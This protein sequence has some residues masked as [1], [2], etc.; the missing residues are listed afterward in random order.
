MGRL[1]VQ[2]SV[3]DFPDALEQ[4]ARRRPGGAVAILV[5]NAAMTRTHE[6]ARLGKPGDR[7]TQVSTVHGE[8]QELRLVVLPQVANI[9]AHVGRH[10]VPW[11]AQMVVKGFQS[12]LVYREFGNRS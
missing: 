11:R 10:A 1:D 7:A 9:D 3:A 8:N 5:I 6:Q 12:R 4:A 2:L